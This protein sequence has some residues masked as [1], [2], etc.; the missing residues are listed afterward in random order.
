[1]RRNWDGMNPEAPIL[2]E[3]EAGELLVQGQPE[4]GSDT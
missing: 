3:T 1:M 4:M 2:G